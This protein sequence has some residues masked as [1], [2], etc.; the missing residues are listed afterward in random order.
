MTDKFTVSARS[1]VITRLLTE[2]SITR[3]VSEPKTSIPRQLTEDYRRTKSHEDLTEPLS[4]IY[5]M[6]R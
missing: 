1:N 5:L 2:G 4:E 3:R 6:E